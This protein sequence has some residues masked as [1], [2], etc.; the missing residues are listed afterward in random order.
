M[1]YHTEFYGK[2]KLNKEMDEKLA[3]YIE[4]FSQTRRVKRDPKILEEMGLGKKEDF[5]IDGGFFVDEDLIEE[6]DKGNFGNDKSI[7]NYNLPPNGQPGLWCQ[8]TIDRERKNIIWDGGEKFYNAEE[9][10][11]YLSENFLKPN[12]YFINGKILA[13]GEEMEDIWALEAIDGE[14]NSYEKDEIIFNNNES[15]L[16]HSESF[17]I[18]VNGEAALINEGFEE[19]EEDKFRLKYQFNHVYGGLVTSHS[20][21]ELIDIIEKNKLKMLLDGNTIETYEI[22]KLEDQFIELNLEN[23]FSND[24]EIKFDKER[25]VNKKMLIRYYDYY[26]QYII[27]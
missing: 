8:W 17:F 14:V 22:K 12:G 6:K 3:L 24:I 2:F 7:V 16:K 21:K 27:I 26:E 1:G 13:S 5:G 11:V 18:L 4:K 10:L 15:N 23:D 25:K 19:D 20:E 9:W